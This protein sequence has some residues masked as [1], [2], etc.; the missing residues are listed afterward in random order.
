MSKESVDRTIGITAILISSITLIM[1]I[2]Q[3]NIMYKQSRLSVTPRLSFSTSL[4]LQDSMI[5]FS[6]SL[7]N[8]GI[9]PALINNAVIEYED[10][11][12]PLDFEAF[13]K[14]QFSE[15]LQLGD[16][17]YTSTFPAGSSFA[18]N[19]NRNIFCER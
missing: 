9:G 2:Y 10:S 5:L 1:F 6:S 19:E 13:F 11:I 16:L 18:I 17:L 12:Y 3:T 7:R 14:A 15:L 8:N 4:N